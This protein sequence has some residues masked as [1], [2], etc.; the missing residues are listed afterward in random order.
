MLIGTYCG[1]IC[2]ITNNFI[3]QLHAYRQCNLSNTYIDFVVGDQ[4][5]SSLKRLLIGDM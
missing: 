3:Y 2:L 5:L 1:I 4:L